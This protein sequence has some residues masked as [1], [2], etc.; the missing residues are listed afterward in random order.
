MPPR[1][2]RFA[3]IIDAPTGCRPRRIAETT[4]ASS[5]TRGV[6]DTTRRRQSPGAFPGLVEVD[7]GTLLIGDPLYR[8]PR[9]AEG[10]PGIDYQAVIEGTAGYLAGQ[11]VLLLGGFGGDG[12]F[13]VYGEFDEYGEMTRATVEFVGPDEDE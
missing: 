5:A 1:A 6:E 10:T 8:L 9:L 13:P 7:S 11:P 3:A 4:T 12:S 2:T